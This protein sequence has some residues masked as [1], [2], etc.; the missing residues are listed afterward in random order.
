MCIVSLRISLPKYIHHEAV[1]S[2]LGQG[3]DRIR[4][5][6]ELYFTKK[7]NTKNKKNILRRL[8]LQQ[9]QIVPVIFTTKK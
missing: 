9:I 2:Q 7:K 3:F 4:R 1:Q 5:M 8:L 6:V